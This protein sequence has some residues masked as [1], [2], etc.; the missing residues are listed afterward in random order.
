MSRYPGADGW[1]YRVLFSIFKHATSR[2]GN[3]WWYF[4]PQQFDALS[5]SISDINDRTAH[6]HIA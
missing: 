6:E 5:T 3:P 1:L 4:T 2:F